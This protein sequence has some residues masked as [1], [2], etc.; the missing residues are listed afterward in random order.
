MKK[1][2]P[3]EDEIRKSLHEGQTNRET[4]VCQDVPEEVF[5]QL[6]PKQKLELLKKYIRLGIQYGYQVWQFDCMMLD[7]VTIRYRICKAVLQRN[8]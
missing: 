6:A 2:I 1:K 8:N 4:F 3:L 5:V 7:K